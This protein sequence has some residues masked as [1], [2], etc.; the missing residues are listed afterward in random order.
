MANSPLDGLSGGNH[1]GNS[2]NANMLTLRIS[3]AARLHEGHV[4]TRGVISAI[5]PLTKLVKSFNYECQSCHVIKELAGVRWADG[6]PMLYQERKK[7]GRCINCGHDVFSSRCEYVNAIII[8]IRDLDTYSDID[9]S[10]VVLLEEDTKNVYNHLGEVV[11]V[12]GQIHTFPSQQFQ[13]KFSSYLY[14]ESIRYESSQELVITDLDKEAILRFTRLNGNRIIDSLAKLFVRDVIGYEIVKKGLLL[15]AA[16]TNRDM[17]QKKLNAA[18]IGDPGLVKSTLLRRAVRLVPNSKYESAQ[19][20][21]GKS[22]TAIVE[23]QEES[24]ILRIGPIPAA[25]GAICALNEI[26]RMHFDDQKHLL[27]VMQEQFFTINKYGISALSL[28]HI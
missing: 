12:S 20:S 7:P 25:K 27:D 8:E 13:Q 11:T 16:S 2:N 26:G 3:E 5:L 14:A 6:K 17:T 24:H 18:L 10:R 23:K 9:P 28:I 21:S 4:K 22:L 1:T 19:N 15:L